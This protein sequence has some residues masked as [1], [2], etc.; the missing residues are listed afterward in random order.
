[1]NNNIENWEKI[2]NNLIENELTISTME[3]CTGGGI[4]N[5]ITNISGASS[6]IKE[7]FVTYCNEAKIKHGVPAII[8]EQFTVYSPEVAIAMAKAVK[9]QTG[10]NIGIGVTGQLGRIDPANPVDKLN[11]VWYSI[12]DEDNNIIIR[13]I[14]IPDGERREQKEYI[15]NEISNSLLNIKKEIEN[16]ED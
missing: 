16:Q 15:L 1:M 6:I 3:S 7:S 9:E 10:S 11:T 14:H 2:V 13:E 5:E 4:A 8:I 12:I